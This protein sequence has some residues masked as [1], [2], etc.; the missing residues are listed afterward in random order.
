M[1]LSRIGALGALTISLVASRVF[2]AGI[3][4]HDVSSD[5]FIALAK[6]ASFATVVRITAAGSTSGG[7]SAVLIDRQW[8]L[9]AAHVVVASDSVRYVVHI[10]SVA[11]EIDSVIV[12][13]MYHAKKDSTYVDLALVHLRSPL[14]RG[15]SVATLSPRDVS[16]GTRV[17]SVGF[18]RIQNARSTTPSPS[19]V[20]HAVENV[21]DT[22]GRGNAPRSYIGADLDNP[23]DSTMSTTGTGR[24]LPLEGV[25][26][27]GDSGGG[28]FVET[29]S[30]WQLVGIV[31]AS[32]YQRQRLEQFATFGWYGALSFW[33]RLDSERTW[34][35]GHVASIR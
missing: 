13:P 15:T 3:F 1:S 27:A 14:P 12:H 35:S 25:T 6:H 7:G 20:R 11:H 16:M 32:E 2:A 8:A 9:T 26:Y 24:A 21:I 28:L 31:S 33:T 10:D 19:G 4:R 5:A 30:G 29:A 23:D 17:V 18:G 22:A 34:I